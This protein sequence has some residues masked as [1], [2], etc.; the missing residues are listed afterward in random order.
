MRELRLCY[1]FVGPTSVITIGSYVF[2][3]HGYQ[4]QTINYLLFQLNNIKKKKK[5][6]RLQTSKDAKELTKLQNWPPNIELYYWFYDDYFSW[7]I[8]LQGVNWW[9]HACSSL[10]IGP[11]KSCGWWPFFLRWCHALIRQGWGI[12]LD[13]RDNHR[14]FWY[15]EWPCIQ[16]NSCDK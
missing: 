8:I 14:S 12:C 6:S 13:S 16:V 4:D 15:S 7:E 9:H 1:S 10:Y 11:G 5:T 3:S 2:Y